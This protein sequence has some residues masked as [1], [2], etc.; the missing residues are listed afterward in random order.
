MKNPPPLLLCDTQDDTLCIFKNNVFL[1]NL[2]SFSVKFRDFAMFWY[3]QTNCK[4][5]LQYGITRRTTLQLPYF[6]HSSAFMP[7]YTYSKPWIESMFLFEKSKFAKL[8]VKR[9][10]CDS[11]TTIIE[12]QNSIKITCW[13]LELLVQNLGKPRVLL[14]FSCLSHPFFLIISKNVQGGP[15]K[16]SNFDMLSFKNY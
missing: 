13:I 14:I 8:E 10:C 5:K 7:L 11:Y 12:T 1:G 9:K 2:F 6:P 16:R 4:P 15:K 3:L